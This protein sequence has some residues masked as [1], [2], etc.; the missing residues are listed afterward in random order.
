ME[1]GWIDPERACYVSDLARGYDYKDS[2][3]TLMRLTGS[4]SIDMKQVS[5]DIL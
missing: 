5:T 4:G 3:P 2:G 1:A